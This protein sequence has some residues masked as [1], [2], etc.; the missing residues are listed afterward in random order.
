MIERP[1][2]RKAGKVALVLCGA[3]F[4][5]VCSD[6]DPTGP[7]VATLQVVGDAN[8]E[9]T[10]ASVQ[11]VEFRAVNASGSGV[12]GVELELSATAG[13]LSSS[14]VTTGADGVASVQWT[15]GTVAGEQRL[16]ATRGGLTATVRVQALPGPASEIVLSASAVSFS[17]LGDEQQVTAEVRDAYGNVIP[18]AE[19]TWSS[20]D[21]D[22]ATVD[23][24]LITAV[25]PGST[26]VRAT[27]GAAEGTVTVGVQ[28]AP[29]KVAISV[30]D[31]EL[32]ALGHTRQLDA[33]VTDAGGSPIVDA[34]VDWTTLNPAVAGVSPEG[35]VE[36]RAEGA[37]R[38]V[39][40][41]GTAADTVEIT[42]RQ[43]P[44][45]VIVTPPQQQVLIG[46]TVSFAAEARDS[47]G[48]VIGRATFE[49][50]SSHENVATVDATGLA[51]AHAG[52]VAIITA[53]FEGV[54]GSARLLVDFEQPELI[55]AAGH[56]HTIFL[57]DGTV[58]GMG[59]R[60]RGQLTGYDTLPALTPIATAATGFKQIAAGDYFSMG[61]KAD[62]TVWT[63]GINDRSQLGRPSTEQCDVGFGTNPLVPCSTT[64]GQVALPLPA[65]KVVA[66]RDHGLALLVD[67]TVWAWGRNTFGQIGHGGSTDDVPTPVQVTGLPKVIDIAAGGQFSLAVTADGRMWG[68]GASS[69]T[70]PAICDGTQAR[71]HF[72]PV[73]IPA[74]TDVVAVSAGWFTA[75]ALR[76]DGTVWGCGGNNFG[77]VGSGSEASSIYFMQQVADLTDVVGIA[78]GGY[79]GIALRADGTVWTW[80]W[81]S[82]NR[83]G[84]DAGTLSRVPG[85]VPVSDIVAIAGGMGHTVVMDSAGRIWTWG[86]NQSGQLGDGTTTDRLQ[87][88]QVWP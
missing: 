55:L 23:A 28:Q 65:V 25:G 39:A 80:G 75:R 49:W 77:Q 19:V 1:N 41:A 85:Q 7:S 46:G 60:R 83:L 69:S 43:V 66:G 10:V 11:T 12:S 5:A 71:D 21:E 37:A 34:Q 29:A 81:N 68:W 54:S 73:R 64:P 45:Q 63:W 17:S 52:G 40:S 20:D 22:V 16:T 8:R 32:R 70:S 36:A 67:S 2:R 87:P 9:A 72:V 58:Y 86:G 74:I 15:L 48:A 78:S 38:I 30:D 88:V 62:G 24:G 26:T 3:L 47:A 14:R 35:L 61:L 57:V 56:E 42:V 76:R 4:L 82:Q 44:A 51:T 59:D 27:S 79:H 13:S 53:S 31:A 18:D 33:A 6:D 84:W 50:T